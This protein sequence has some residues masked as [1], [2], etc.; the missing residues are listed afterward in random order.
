M[1]DPSGLVAE[2]TGENLFAVRKGV[3]YT[4]HRSTRCRKRLTRDSIMTIAKDLGYEVR[5]EP[6]SRDQL[7]M[8]WSAPRPKSWAF[9]N[10]TS[11]HRAGTARGPITKK[12]ADTFRARGHRRGEEIPRLARP[13]QGVISARRSQS[14]GSVEPPQK[15]AD[16]L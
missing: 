9:A 6:L 3:I 14:W 13:L 11:G 1:L 10:S 7:L 15:A 4:P 16:Y 5:E 12:L 8:S 2:G